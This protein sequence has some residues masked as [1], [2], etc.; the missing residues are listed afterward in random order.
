M[1]ID[2]RAVARPE[3]LTFFA[4][5]ARETS[6]LSCS[7]SASCDEGTSIAPSDTALHFRPTRTQPRAR[8]RESGCRGQSAYLPS[9]RTRRNRFLAHWLW[10]RI[11]VVTAG[12][13]IDKVEPLLTRQHLHTLCD[14]RRTRRH[15]SSAKLGGDLTF[16]T[17]GVASFLEAPGVSFFRETMRTNSATSSL[18]RPSLRRNHRGVRRRTRGWAMHCTSIL[19]WVRVSR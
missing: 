9:I 16:T 4:R 10:A 14:R 15:V 7:S 12:F 11:R 3:E 1:T 17:R 6:A 18:S 13:K 19:A 8:M 5:D 2:G